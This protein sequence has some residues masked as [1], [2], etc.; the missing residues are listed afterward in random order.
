MQQKK[1]MST[2]HEL[3]SLE[4]QKISFENK[5]SSFSKNKLGLGEEAKLT[6]NLWSP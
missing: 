2:Y 4:E 5:D 1:I 3:E 6:T